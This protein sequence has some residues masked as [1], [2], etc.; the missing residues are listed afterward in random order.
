MNKLLLCSFLSLFTY[1]IFAQ[2]LTD[3]SVINISKIDQ[4]QLVSKYQI[5]IDISKRLEHI[6][7]KMDKV[8][9]I[10]NNDKYP[11]IVRALTEELEKIKATKK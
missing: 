4:F 8:N 5:F 1:G 3:S 2:P 9:L 11:E 6:L 10:F 7:P